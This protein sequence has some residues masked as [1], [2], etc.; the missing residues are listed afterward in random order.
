MNNDDRNFMHLERILA[1]R[2][3]DQD[4]RP[5]PQHNAFMVFWKKV[6]CGSCAP[7]KPDT[8]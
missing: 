4:F 2:S 5:V 8:C 6:G 1:I 7:D 3:G